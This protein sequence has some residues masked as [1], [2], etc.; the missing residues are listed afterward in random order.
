MPDTG[1]AKSFSVSLMIRFDRAEDIWKEAA[2][3]TAECNVSQRISAG[4]KGELNTAQIS[5][6]DKTV[7]P[8]SYEVVPQNK[9]EISV[10]AGLVKGYQQLNSSKGWSVKDR[11]LSLQEWYCITCILL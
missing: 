6:G 3:F 9:K 5:D 10:G 4:R 7:S 2:R 1:S 11:R 8:V